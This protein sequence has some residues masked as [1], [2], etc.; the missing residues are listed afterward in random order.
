MGTADSPRTIFDK[1][2]DAH[3][4]VASDDGETLLYVDRHYILDAGSFHA[5][6]NLRHQGRTVRSPTQT[7]GI[8]DHYVPTKDRAA[9]IPDPE[10]RAVVAMFESNTRAANI[11]TF[12]IG[13][14]RQGIVHVVGPEQG[15]SQPGMLIVCADSHTSTHGALGAFAFGIGH[16]EGTHVLATQ[17]LWQRKPRQLRITVDGGLSRGVTAKDLILAIIA[18]IGAG[19]AGGHVVEYAGTTIRALSVEQRMTVCNMSIEAGAKAGIIAPDE[20]TLAY[21][22]GRPFA[23]RGVDWDRSVAYAR[24]LPTDALA[25]FDREFAFDAS[26]VEPMV[27]WGTSPEHAAPITGEVPDPAEVT[28]ASRRAAIERAIA[29]MGLRPRAKIAEIGIDYVFIGSCTN[30]RIED[31]RAAARILDGRRSKVPGFVAPGSTLVKRQAEDEG[32]DRIFVAAGLEW[33]DS[34]CSMCM[35][36]NGDLLSAGQRCAATSNRNFEGRQGRGARTHL[37]SPAMAAAAA[38][39][40]HL[41][42]VRELI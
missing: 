13:D 30:G 10:A 38:I 17:T 4:V 36:I 29:Y 1:I 41:A 6:E 3:A 2:W 7:F 35:G 20:A 33:R 27:T 39:G 42:D 9:G 37:M 34:G 16:S 14:P 25:S 28:D 32:L 26:A 31:L 5:F 11:V 22:A 12:G 23:P 24:T 8:A 15:L 21:V 19:G 18:R 40:G